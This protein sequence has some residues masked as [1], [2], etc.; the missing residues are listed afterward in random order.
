M[1][2]HRISALQCQNCSSNKLKLKRIILTKV[3]HFIALAAR[4]N[5]V[6]NGE[7]AHLSAR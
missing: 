1:C 6:D 3:H 7:L 2:V 5:P 4:T